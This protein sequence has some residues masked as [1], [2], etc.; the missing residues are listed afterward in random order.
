MDI[1]SAM[2]ELRK[3]YTPVN[4]GYPL[5][6]SYDDLYFTTSRNRE[7]GFFTS[8][9]PGGVA[10]HNPTCCDDIYSYRWTDFIRLDVSGQVF[11]NEKTEYGPKK[12][13][14]DFNFAKA[15]DSIKPMKGAVRRII[16][17]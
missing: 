2:G 1:F 16:Y 6:S 11:P 10:L 17:D 13:Y 4:I 14:N 7:D 12:D 15:A 8:N 9:R 3:W 5:N